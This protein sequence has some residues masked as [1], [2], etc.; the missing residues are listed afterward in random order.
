MTTPQVV[1]T[2]V[3][4]NNNSPIQDYV[5][6]QTIILNQVLMKWLLGSTFYSPYFHFV[7][8]KKQSEKKKK[9]ETSPT[10]ILFSRVRM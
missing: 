6:T 2:W 3:T 4:V 9:K 8:L 5:D 1:K 7:Q 10:V